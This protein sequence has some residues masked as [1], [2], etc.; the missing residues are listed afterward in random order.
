[1]EKTMTCFHFW[2]TSRSMLNN[3][4]QDSANKELIVET[5]L[6][7]EDDQGTNPCPGK[8]DP[9]HAFRGRNCVLDSDWS[10]NIGPNPCARATMISATHISFPVSA[11]DKFMSMR[12][13]RVRAHA[14]AT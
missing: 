1:M 2:T 6:C 12:F 3:T 13:F 9:T 4:Q 5:V 8:V 7:R 11:F 14:A 10:R